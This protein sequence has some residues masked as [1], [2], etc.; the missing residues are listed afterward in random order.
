M[1]HF[2]VA[3]VVLAVS[4][5]VNSAPVTFSDF[6]TQKFVPKNCTDND[7][8]DLKSFVLDT[9]QFKVELPSSNSVH[10]GQTSYMGYEV[11][12]PAKYQK[13][14]VVQYI[15][16]CVYDSEVR[17]NKVIKE[18]RYQ[19]EFFGELRKFS[20]PDWAIDSIDNDP[21]YKNFPKSYL[22][23]P[24]VI[25]KNRHGL[26]YWGKYR[27]YS[28]E[29]ENIIYKRL[30]DENFFFT[31]DRPATAFLTGLQ[32]KNTSLEFKACLYKTKDI[33]ETIGSPQFFIPNPIHCFGYDHKIKF[34]HKKQK[35]YTGQ[36][37]E[38]VCTEID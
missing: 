20:H 38:A 13:Y 11:N 2:F 7:L 32:A 22:Q 24:A 15:K 30:P 33:P 16:G 5:V 1:I 4:A 10:Y 34:N 36:S 9:R 26:Y 25:N 35:Y 19:R 18:I 3:S 6:E 37:M 29:R 8:C 31:V 23:D 28:K 21:M 27:E 12:D 17:S 14:A